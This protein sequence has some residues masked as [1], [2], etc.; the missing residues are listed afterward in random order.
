MRTSGNEV[1][2]K[3]SPEHAQFFNR[4]EFNNILVLK[5]HVVWTEE[6]FPKIPFTVNCSCLGAFSQQ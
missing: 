4:S 6:R 1:L 2:P 5:L 3:T